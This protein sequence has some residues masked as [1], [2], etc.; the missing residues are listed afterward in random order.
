VEGFLLTEEEILV[1]A[2]YEVMKEA[3]LMLNGEDDFCIVLDTR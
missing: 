2:N 1:K 3:H